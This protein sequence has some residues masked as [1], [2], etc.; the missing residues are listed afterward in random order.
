VPLASARWF[1][2]PPSPRRAATVHDE[3][4]SLFFLP[5]SASI[6]LRSIAPTA[7]TRNTTQWQWQSKRGESESS[8]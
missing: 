8:S 1:L 7:S 4:A 5:R 6:G 2:A 3:S